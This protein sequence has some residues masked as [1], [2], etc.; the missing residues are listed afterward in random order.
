M[1][2]TGRPYGRLDF[3]TVTNKL[4]LLINLKCKSKKYFRKG[5]KGLTK[6]QEIGKYDWLASDNE[7]YILMLDEDSNLVLSYNNR[8]RVL[9]KRKTRGKGDRLVME[10]NGNLIIYENENNTKVWESKTA[11]QGEYFRLESDANLV[12]YDSQGNSLWSTQLG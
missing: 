5:G 4:I 2:Q 8:N 11:L 12:V 7:K 9:W 1:T 3:F 6:E 10:Q